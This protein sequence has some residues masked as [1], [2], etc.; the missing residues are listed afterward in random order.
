[1]WGVQ[2][3]SVMEGGGPAGI[4]SSI[5]ETHCGWTLGG[6]KEVGDGLPDESCILGSGQAVRQAGLLQDG[7]GLG[8]LPRQEVGSTEVT[9]SILN[10][11]LCSRIRIVDFILKRN[12]AAGGE[13]RGVRWPVQWPTR[14]G[15]DVGRW[16]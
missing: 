11:L 16:E 15:V 13:D 14:R 3:G 8:D 1:M 2:V 5:L 4:W 7:E 6:F 12:T 10:Q 9:R